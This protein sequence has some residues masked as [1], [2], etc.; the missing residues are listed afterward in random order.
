MRS[1]TTL[2]DD[3]IISAL[4]GFS[5]TPSP[6]SPPGSFSQE[7]LKTKVK[8]TLSKHELAMCTAM[9]SYTKR[10]P[11]GSTKVQMRR[12]RGICRHCKAKTMWYCPGCYDNTEG[13]KRAWY[14]NSVTS[15]NCHQRHLGGV[16]S[17]C[18][19]LHSKGHYF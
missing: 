6:P 3:S 15:P 8:D 4:T 7:A 17:K 19:E 18:I 9:T 10:L 12:V 16:E 13:A 11:D 1:N 14:C 2:D 5:R